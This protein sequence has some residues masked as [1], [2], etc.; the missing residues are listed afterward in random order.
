MSAF[1][2]VVLAF[3]LGAVAGFVAGYLVRRR[4]PRDPVAVPGIKAAPKAD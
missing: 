4:N 2:H 1:L 3:V